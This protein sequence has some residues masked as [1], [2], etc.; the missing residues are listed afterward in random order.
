MTTKK[1]WGGRRPNQTGRPRI[2]ISE[3]KV[4][5]GKVGIRVSAESAA[6]AQRLML[7]FGEVANVEALYELAIVKLAEHTDD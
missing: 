2:P 3:R 5:A 7:H 4:F 1:T 6:L